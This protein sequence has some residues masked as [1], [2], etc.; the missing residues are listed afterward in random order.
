MQNVWL[1]FKNVI[2]LSL[3]GFIFLVEYGFDTV[4]LFSFSYSLILNT[5][6]SCSVI[7]IA[8]K[9]M[10]LRIYSGLDLK[11]LGS[12]SVLRCRMQSF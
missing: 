1:I 5:F 7:V 6:L 3:G 10:H 9:I 12:S 8:I 4:F 2:Q 11:N